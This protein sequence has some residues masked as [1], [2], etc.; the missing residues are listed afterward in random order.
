MERMRF[1]MDEKGSILI[2]ALVMLAFLTLLG[3][4]VTNTSTIEVQIAGN[5]RFHKQN[6]YR[7]E[8]AAMEAAQRLQNESDK[9][10]LINRTATWLH[11]SN[12]MT[13]LSNWDHDDAGLNDNA[14][15]ADASIDP[16]NTTYFS[17]VD[18]G[19]ITGASLAMGGTNVHD[20]AILGLCDRTDGQAM[21]EIGYRKRF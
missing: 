7:A 4:S 2:I 21:V 3:I 12:T 1:P 8:A 9:Q 20:Y 11:D 16:D 15:T 14:E 18:L 17:V 5:E 6:F 10:T 13:D 19:I